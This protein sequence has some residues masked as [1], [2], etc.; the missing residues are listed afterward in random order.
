MGM[1]ASYAHEDPWTALQHSDAIRPIHEAIGGEQIFLNM[2]LFRGLNL[3]HLG[4]LTAAQRT[5]E[6]IVAADETLGVA[7][8]CPGYAP[9][10]VRST[11]RAP[12]RPSSA[13][14]V[15]R[16]TIRSKRV[17]DAGCSQR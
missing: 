4:A 17:G 11:R 6:G 14:T 16:I 10:S 3:W 7:S 15:D 12:W 13:T 1:R 5:L 9:T 2:Q 8:A